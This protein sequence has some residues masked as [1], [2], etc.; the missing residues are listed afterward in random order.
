MGDPST[1]SDKSRAGSRRTLSQEP[2]GLG[3]CPPGR[4]PSSYSA[5]LEERL[6]EMRAHLA[7]MRPESDAEALQA[8]RAA[9]PE[10]T[11]SARVA[12][13]AGRRG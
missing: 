7:R 9:F 13:I 1:R 5:T 12:A 10:T 8:L 11:L 2:A 4:D 3:E 6:V